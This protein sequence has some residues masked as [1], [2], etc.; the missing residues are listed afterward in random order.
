MTN[1]A[2]SKIAAVGYSLTVWHGT[3]GREAFPAELPADVRRAL[4]IALCPEVAA[5]VAAARSV[6]ALLDADYEA[7]PTWVV[8]ALRVALAAADRA[9]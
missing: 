3:D 2:D 4:A 7:D 5:V 8:D 1:P 6:V 9:R